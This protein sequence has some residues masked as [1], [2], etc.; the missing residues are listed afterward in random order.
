MPPR[1]LVPAL[2]SGMIL[3]VRPVSRTL[4]YLLIHALS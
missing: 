2:I 4:L 1:F 3:T